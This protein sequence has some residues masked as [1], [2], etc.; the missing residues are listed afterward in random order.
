MKKTFPYQIVNIHTNSRKPGVIY[1]AIVDDRNELCVSATLDYCMK[2][3][4]DKHKC[5]Q[6][7]III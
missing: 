2:W 4:R 6:T 5:F 1:A 3:I 7:N